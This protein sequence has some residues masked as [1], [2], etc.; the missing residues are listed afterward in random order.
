MTGEEAE[1]ILGPELCAQLDA[2]PV[3]PLSPE[4]ID[5]LAR[6]FGPLLVTKPRSDA[7]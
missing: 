7:A 4:Q 3:K 1:A 2:R 6:I 5:F